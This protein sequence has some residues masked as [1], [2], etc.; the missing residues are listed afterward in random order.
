MKIKELKKEIEVMSGKLE[1]NFKELKKEID[2]M[3]WKLEDKTREI[4]RLE[5]QLH[6]ASCSAQQLFD[7]ASKY[8]ST[9]R[10]VIGMSI[11]G[12]EEL[13]KLV[14]NP[15]KALTLRMEERQREPGSHKKIEDKV[16][17]GA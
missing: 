14:E 4:K 9:F 13:W 11:V 7:R 17:K 5:L 10:K 6:K 2:V 12:F 15:L 16:C 8:P 1:D 3:N